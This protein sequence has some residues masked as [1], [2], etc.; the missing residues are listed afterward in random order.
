M[1]QDFQPA[2]SFNTTDMSL[3]HS[4]PELKEYLNLTTLIWLKLNII[5]SL[6]FFLDLAWFMTAH[7]TSNCLILLSSL[8]LLLSCDILS[9]SHMMPNTFCI[10]IAFFPPASVARDRNLLS[11]CKFP[12]KTGS[13]KI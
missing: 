8:A 7:T 4:L 6:Y 13:D 11:K 2:D 10:F 12:G 3:I 9:L 5:L 1:H